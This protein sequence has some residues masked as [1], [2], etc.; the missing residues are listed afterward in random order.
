M[1]RSLFLSQWL[2]RAYSLD[3]AERHLLAGLSDPSQ[4]AWPALAGNA[5]DYAAV[6]LE[7]AQ[8]RSDYAS[9][10]RKL[11]RGQ[12]DI[13]LAVGYAKTIPGDILT[14]CLARRYPGTSIRQISQT[15]Q[16]AIFGDL[17]R[18]ARAGL[19][20]CEHTR[21]FLTPTGAAA[22]RF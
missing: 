12:R 17:R 19:L 21:W 14:A 3:E 2:S 6:R 16:S 4:A 22:L 5:N 1:A 7:M 8:I 15:Q 20:D 11:T 13:L 10:R 18:C 9:G